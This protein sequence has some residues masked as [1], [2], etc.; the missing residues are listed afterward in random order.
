MDQAS[1]YRQRNCSNHEEGR[2]TQTITP[3]SGK[4]QLAAFRQHQ[5][6]P[7]REQEADLT[8]IQSGGLWTPNT[9]IRIGGFY[10]TPETPI[11]AHFVRL[12]KGFNCL[13][14]TTTNPYTKTYSIPYTLL[15]SHP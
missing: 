15:S 1:P 6:G 14:Q 2:G 11:Q 4:D 8:T 10:P 7:S 5:K 13:S 9:I 12:N 3:A